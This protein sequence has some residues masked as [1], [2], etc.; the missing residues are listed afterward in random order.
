LARVWFAPLALLSGA[1]ACAST[2]PKAKSATPSASAS[3]A[4]TAAPTAVPPANTDAP[5]PR[6]ADADAAAAYYAERVVFIEKGDTA[7]MAATDF[8]RLRRGRMYA[9]TESVPREL[10]EAIEGAMAKDD[11]NAVL[12]LATKVLALDPTDIRAQLL[13]ATVLKHGGAAGEANLH[14]S[15]AKALI[16]SIGR[17]GDGKSID[18]AWTVYAV[19]EEYHFLLALGLVVR[20]QRLLPHAER[21]FDVL[22]VQDPKTGAAGEA[23]FD[24][25][26]LFAEEGRMLSP[27]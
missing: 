20:G 1:A 27:K 8:A 9:K 24:V 18:S 2:T 15:V 23:Y 12:D 17:T 19:K 16:E 13:V 6:P 14:A 26:E 21:T 11:L 10:D 5:P 3:A 7:G 22:A 25:S 4:T